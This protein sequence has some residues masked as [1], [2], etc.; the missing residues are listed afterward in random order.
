MPAQRAAICGL[1]LAA[2]VEPV[3]VAPTGGLRQGAPVARVLGAI[4]PDNKRRNFLRLLASLSTGSLRP[5][6]S[7]RSIASAELSPRA[8]LL[9]VA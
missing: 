9:S 8:E 3:V 2:A 6:S 7:S 4:G 1:A 5:Y